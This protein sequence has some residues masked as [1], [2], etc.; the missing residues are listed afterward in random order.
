MARQRQLQ[1]A[2]IQ[3][4]TPQALLIHFQDVAEAS[5]E[6][7]HT[8]IP[9]TALGQFVDLASKAKEQPITTLELVP[10]LVTPSSPNYEKIHASVQDALKATPEDSEG[11]EDSED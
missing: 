8:D 7:V 10:P 3:Q 4:F 2:F 6:F 11:S 9:R 1:E 5:P